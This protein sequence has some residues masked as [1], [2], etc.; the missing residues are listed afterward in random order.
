M[1]PHV[2]LAPQRTDPCGFRVTQRLEARR[3]ALLG[4]I[5]EAPGL[6]VRDLDDDAADATGDRGRA[7]QSAS[8]TVSPKPSRMDF[9]MTTR[10]CTW[11][12]LTST[13]P[14]LLRF[15]RM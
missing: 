12:A 8:L 1:R 5:D 9:W 2:L 15:E 3:R 10:E 6:A 14:T 7:F 11:N 13:E 4:G